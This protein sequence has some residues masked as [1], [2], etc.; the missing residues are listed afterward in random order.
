[1]ILNLPDIVVRLLQEYKLS[2]LICK[3]IF[4]KIAI[5]HM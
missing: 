5:L 4:L 2:T 1:M 3:V